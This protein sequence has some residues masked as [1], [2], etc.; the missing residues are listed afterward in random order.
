MNKEIVEVSNND[1]STPETLVTEINIIKSN[2]ENMAIIGAIQIGIKLA[3]LKELVS[4][5]DWYEYIEENI[6]FS[7]RKVENLIKFAN[8]YGNEKSAYSNVISNTHTCADLSY[9]NALRLLTIPEND[10]E[11]FVEKV[12]IEEKSARELDEEIKRFKEE[13]EELEKEN[14]SIQEELE[15]V[16]SELLNIEDKYEEEKS[17]LSKELEI[18]IEELKD[19]AE[20]H[21][22]EKERLE[23]E[24]KKGQA[25][26]P[27]ELK[28]LEEEI[29]K[30]KNA[31]LEIEKANKE[32]LDK[33]TAEMEKEKA[34]AIEKH[35]EELNK[36]EEELERVKTKADKNV[37][38]NI[39]E[40]KLLTD[41]LQLN[42]KKIKSCIDKADQEQG[43]KMQ[44]ALN[45]LLDM[46]KE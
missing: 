40:F 37:D 18:K 25:E 16:K 43:I 24:K 38:T 17:S 34:I 28:K 42:V 8:H 31:K 21:E 19:E 7:K 44:A 1:I 15:L 29:E 33:M 35:H 6:G 9:S 46:I 45:K 14:E 23:K 39:L 20:L 30:L 26:N 32:Q 11:E 22:R 13:K 2:V 27:K 41:D 12:D 10:I 5:G 3:K 4:H 36:A